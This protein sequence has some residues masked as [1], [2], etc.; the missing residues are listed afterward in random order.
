MIATAPIREESRCERSSVRQGKRKPVKP[1]T[2]SMMQSETVGNKV[3]DTS[4]TVYIFPERGA[5]TMRIT[6]VNRNGTESKLQQVRDLQ[7]T[8]LPD[9]AV[10][11]EFEALQART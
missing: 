3:S 6:S 4:G 2:T 1:N 9:L 11:Q 5:N 8:A 10:Y 7:G